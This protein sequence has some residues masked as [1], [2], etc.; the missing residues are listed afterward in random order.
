MDRNIIRTAKKYV[1][2]NNIGMLKN[3]YKEVIDCDSEYKFNIPSIYKEVFLHACLHGEIEV[4]TFLISFYFEMDD[5]SQVLLRQIFPYGKYI[6]R[7]D[8][9]L[10]Y[11]TSILP[12]V[13]AK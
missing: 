3:L 7:G 11:D 10:W 8:L 2:E 6:M 13:R 5:I 12:L 1:M 9:I 4:I